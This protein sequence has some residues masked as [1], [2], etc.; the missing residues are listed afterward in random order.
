MAPT[1]TYPPPLAEPEHRR[2]RLKVGAV[3]GKAARPDLCGGREVTR[4]PTATARVSLLRCSDVSSGSFSTELVW[5][6]RSLR[7]AMPPI[8]TEFTRH[9]ESS[10]R[11]TSGCEQSQH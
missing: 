1:T 4:V 9:D 7:S 11:A 2:Q 5:T 8:A 10:L 6:K 3:C